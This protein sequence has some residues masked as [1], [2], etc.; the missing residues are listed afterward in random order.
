MK[1]YK[2]GYILHYIDKPLITTHPE[3]FD[4][5]HENTFIDVCQDWKS[6]IDRV[7][8]CEETISSS[9]HGCVISDAYQIPTTWFKLSEKV[10][11][12]GFKFADYLSGTGRE[13]VNIKIGEKYKFPP[14]PNLKELQD[15]LIKV[16]QDYAK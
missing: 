9:L 4:F 15:K 11:G 1:K 13:P 14:I 7:V 16:L 2:I 8:E 12:D 6:F 3:L 10:L 5:S